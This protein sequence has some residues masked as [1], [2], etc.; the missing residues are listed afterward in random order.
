MPSSISSSNQQPEADARNAAASEQEKF[1]PPEGTAQ[2]VRAVRMAIIVLL[3]A[4]A[5]LLVS[6]ELWARYFYPRV[7]RIEA[8]ITSDQRQMAGLVATPA[9]SQAATQG[10][11]HPSVLVLGNSLLLHALD[12][13]R[14]QQDLAPVR[15]VRYGIENTN[16]LDWYYGLRRLFAEGVRPTKVVLALNL[17]Q[18]LSHGVLAESPYKLF[19]AA[20]LWA[21]SRDAGMDTTQTSD[22]VFAHWSAFYAGREGIRNY[23][24]NVTD[25]AYATELHRLARVPPKLPSQEEML[26]QS[27]ARLQNLNELCHSYGVQFTLVVPPALASGG[28]ILLKA[29]DLQGIDVDAP[30][31]LLS[32]GPEYFLADHFHV[33]EKGAALFTEALARDLRARLGK[34]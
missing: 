15:V 17:G 2:Q 5:L 16:Y 26:Q 27:R 33:N 24:L 23:I 34:R 6:T 22:L 7:S 19:R 29:G 32:L 20:D 12:Y 25:P 18:M 13:P 8:R 3:S 28:E 21:I 11:D 30:I 31:P 10:N 4:L 9:T 1:F 14:I